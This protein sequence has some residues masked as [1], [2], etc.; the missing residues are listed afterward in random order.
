[1]RLLTITKTLKTTMGEISLVE[2]VAVAAQ[3][4]EEVKKK[5]LFANRSAEVL[6]DQ[7]NTVAAEVERVHTRPPCE[8]VLHLEVK[9][10]Y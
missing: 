4:K 3:K 9:T 8:E 10:Y 1:M 2:R 6:L 5:V 7:F